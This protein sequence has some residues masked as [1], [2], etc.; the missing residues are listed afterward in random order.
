MEGWWFIKSPLLPRSSVRALY[1]IAWFALSCVTTSFQ[2]ISFHLVSTFDFINLLLFLGPS[3]VS[4]ILTKGC[5]FLGGVALYWLDIYN[6]VCL[7]QV[8][9]LSRYVMRRYTDYYY[10]PFAFCSV[11]LPANWICVFL[12]IR[13]T[14]IPPLSDKYAE[15]L[16]GLPSFRVWAYYF[17]N[18]GVLLYTGNRND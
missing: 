3:L 1:N 2:S 11:P 4:W 8:S 12:K 15:N 10:R 6:R 18:L 13:D 9:T 16:S 7:V 5:P 14:I 17:K